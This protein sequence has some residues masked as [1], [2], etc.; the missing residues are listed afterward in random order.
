MIALF[1]ALISV[2]SFAQPPIRVAIT[3]DDFPTHGKP[4]QGTFYEDVVKTFLDALKKHE[5]K[6]AVA[7][8]NAGKL[9]KSPELK[10]VHDLWKA[11]GHPF[12][13]HSYMHESL[14]D[15]DPAAFEASIVRNEEELKRLGGEW[16]TFRYP[17]LREGNTLEKRNR[18][19]KFLKER[20]YQIAQ[21]TIDF[22]DW[23][24]NPPYTRCADR[25]DN[26]AI[27]WLEESYLQNAIAQFQR[28]T[29]LSRILFKREIAHILL[30][31]IGAFDARMA[32]RLL[33]EYKKLG[34]QFISLK[35]AL[36]DPV[37]Q[38]DPE[39]VAPYGAEFPHQ[40]LR[41]R[42]LKLADVGMTRFTE[43]PEEKLKK[44]CR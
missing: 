36:E 8:I 40:I 23:S 15:T 33:T 26:Q 14:N 24:W 38:I 39:Y 42:G 32:D 27:A 31:H 11:A 6:E 22:E 30:L 16:K 35:E 20:G 4:P 43:Y 18:I 7:Y 19:R 44:L 12:G 5:V 34:A 1:L 41:Q 29:Q 28:S 10:R 17:F 9:E 21:V 3:V 37:Y 25:K 2:P 13:N